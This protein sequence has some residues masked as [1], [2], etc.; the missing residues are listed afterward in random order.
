M[1]NENHTLR[2]FELSLGSTV[3][4]NKVERQKFSEHDL[5]ELLTT[6][7]VRKERFGPYFSPAIFTNN[8]RNAENVERLSL[9]TLDVDN[10]DGSVYELEER[11]QSRLTAR[12][13]VYSTFRHTDECPRIRIVILPER[14]LTVDEHAIVIR[15][16]A[17]DLELELDPCTFGTATAFFLPAVQPDRKPFVLRIERDLLNIDSILD[18]SACEI[19]PVKSNVASNEEFFTDDYIAKLPNAIDEQEVQVLLTC[20][21]AEGLEYDDWLDV[22]MALHHQF[23]GSEDGFS[24]W[25]AWSAKSTKHN[26]KEMLR[27]WRSFK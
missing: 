20:Y 9:I 2:H 1:K 18:R 10:V 4:S 24:F 21:P 14:D 16:I 17:S 5:G 12:S 25:H 7:D 15:A 11:L 19:V 3:K 13:F 26:P 8:L 23:S 27:R 6:H 22:G